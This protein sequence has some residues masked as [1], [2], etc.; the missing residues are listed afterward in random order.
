MWNILSGDF[1]NKMTVE[2]CIEN[3]LDN[4]SPGAIIVFHDNVKSIPILKKALPQILIGIKEKGYK[5]LALD[6]D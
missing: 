4:I 1:D 5:M 6:Q 3:V 2:K